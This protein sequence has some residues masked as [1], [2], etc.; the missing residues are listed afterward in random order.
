MSELSEQAG[1]GMGP[2]I[3]VLVPATLAHIAFVRAVVGAAARQGPALDEDRV[4][5]LEVAV[6]EAVTNAVQAHLEA[7]LAHP[8]RIRVW[9]GESTVTVAVRDEGPGFDPES[10]PELPSPESPER[11][12]HES[13]L[14]VALMG[15]LADESEIRSGPQGT[16]VRLTVHGSGARKTGA[17]GQD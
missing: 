6:T 11:L 4:F 12:L 5:A 9:P 10:V 8:V 3:E 13:G 14:G 17:T 16:E 2:P 1:D 7:D 15:M